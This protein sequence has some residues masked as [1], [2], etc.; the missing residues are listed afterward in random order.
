MP[1]STSTRLAR[2]PWVTWAT[3]LLFFSAA[4]AAPLAYRWM[5][6]PQ[7][8]PLTRQHN[9]RTEVFLR[10]P[11]AWDGERLPLVEATRS[12]LLYLIHQDLPPAPWPISTPMA[13]SSSRTMR[14]LTLI[15]KI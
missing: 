6:R 13:R 2:R 15:E 10:N 3:Y 11:H 7:G 5:S 14:R 12:P 1:A 9:G 4:I 8:L